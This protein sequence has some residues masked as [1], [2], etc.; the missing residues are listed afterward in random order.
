MSKLVLLNT[1]LFVAGADLTA[2]TNKV[3]AQAEV[4]AKEVTTFGSGG[5]KEFLGGLKSGTLA[6]EFKQDFANA[7]LDSI[8][9]P[10]FGTVVTFE[11]R[12]TQSAR[13]TSNPGYTGSVLITQHNPLSGSVGDEASMSVSFPTTGAVARQTT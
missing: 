6:I 7:A 2:V 9:F 13:S 1:R 5:A 11:V 3:T 12:P 4:E 8:L 10:L